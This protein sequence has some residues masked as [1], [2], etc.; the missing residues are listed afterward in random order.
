MNLELKDPWLVAAWPGMGGVA[1]I[2]ATFLAQKLGAK[3]I[4]EIAHAGYFDLRS[5]HVQEGIALAGGWPRSV[6]Y[7]WK[8][9]T[10]GRDLVIFIGDQQA[11]HDGYR[12]CEEMLGIARQL[13]VRRVFTFAAM[14]TMILP[15]ATPRVFAVAS[16]ADVLTEAKRH[17]AEVLQEGEI[18]GLNGVF[19]AAAAA[20]GLDGLCLLGEFPIFVAAFAN[21]KA[22]SAVLRVFSGIADIAIDLDE[23][24]H[25]AREME[26]MHV[27]H[28]RRLQA[29]AEAASRGQNE[30]EA[31]GEEWRKPKSD[32]IS[33]HLKARIES[34][35]AKAHQDRSKA[36]EL[37]AELDRHGVFKRYEDRF[38]DLFKHGA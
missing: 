11:A 22:S 25:Q 20:H 9:P 1:Q 36:L 23:L 12:F 38:L 28:L 4:A 18:S 10:G 21:P 31:E 5:I 34:L 24:D 8:N 6:F 30:Q 26:P 33:P 17:S 29:A 19:L 2:A 15:Q 14:G 13:G 37:K 35:F 32:E 7:G 16:G 3:E 27:E